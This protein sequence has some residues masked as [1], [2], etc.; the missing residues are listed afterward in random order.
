MIKVLF[1][2]LRAHNVSPNFLTIRLDTIIPTE[3]VSNFYSEV[4]TATSTGTQTLQSEAF[5]DLL[6]PQQILKY[7]ATVPRTQL[8]EFPAI[9]EHGTSQLITNY[10]PI[11]C[12]SIR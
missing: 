10:S 5:R 9:Q 2:N 11:I 6:V 7:P 1:Q 3:Q 4:T 8:S 12:G